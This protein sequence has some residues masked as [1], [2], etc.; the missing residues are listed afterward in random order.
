MYDQPRPNQEFY[1]LDLD[2]GETIDRSF[3]E[4]TVAGY[5]R[6][7]L[8]EAAATVWAAAPEAD[9]SPEDEEKLRAL[10]YLQ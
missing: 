3:E 10:G 6:M 7:L 5:L 4:P 8:R 2:P 1:R 9:L